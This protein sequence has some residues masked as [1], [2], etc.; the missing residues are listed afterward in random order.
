MKKYLSLLPLLLIILVGCSENTPTIPSQDIPSEETPIEEPDCLICRKLPQAEKIVLD[1]LPKYTPTTFD[2]S[3]INF[4]TTE[5]ANGVS[6]KIWTFTKND[7]KLSQVVTTE[8]DFNYASIAAGTYENQTSSISLSNIYNHA[9]Y[10]EVFNTSKKVVAATNG[11][12][13]GNNKT[14]NAFVKDSIIIK[15]SHNDNNNYDYTNSS[16]DIPASMPMLFGVSG[17]T[18][19]IAP[20]INGSTK[21]TIKSKLFYNLELLRNDNSTIVTNKVVINQYESKNNINIVF[22]PDMAINV[23]AETTVLKMKRHIQESTRI[24]GEIISINQTTEYSTYRPTEE[25]YYI[26]IPTSLNITNFQVGDVLSYYIN[27][28]DNTWKYYDT[29][30]GCRHALVVNGEIAPTLNLEYSNGAKTT[31]VPRTAV[32]VMPNGNAVIFSVEGLRYGKKSTSDNDPYG[33][34]LKELAEFM[35]YY[36]VYSGANLDGGGSTQ[37]ISINPETEEFEVTVRSSDY[38]TYDIAASRKVINSLLVYIYR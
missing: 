38:G 21:E 10:Y 6:Q 32:G 1:D 19:Q 31:G 30:I 16:A 14:V 33:L 15:D 8:V 22:N 29:I 34:N 35:R 4:K 25:E 24:H 9:L 36:G 12:F 23:S 27:S 37:L 13:F 7:G 2:S 20:I 18:A 11:D 3:T 28:A 5:L 17:N 26:I